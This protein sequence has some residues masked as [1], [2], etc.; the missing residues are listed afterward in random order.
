[1]N[2]NVNENNQSAGK[3]QP[4]QLTQEVVGANYSPVAHLQRAVFRDPGKVALI[5]DDG[6]LTAAQSLDV[7]SRLA[8]YLQDR[9]VGAGD[10]VL[11]IAKNHPLHLLTH[12]ACA[13]LGAV[14]C[15]LNVRLATAEVAAICAR[16]RPQH[17]LTDR[18]DALRWQGDASVEVIADDWLAQILAEEPVELEPIVA[19]EDAVGALVF[20]SGT[21]GE[22]KGALLTH[23]NLW[24]GWRNFREGFGYDRRDTEAVAAPLSHIGG[25]NGLTLDLFVSG[26]TVV[27]IRN[28]VPAQVVETL[29]RHGVAVMFAVPTMYRALVAQVGFSA[30]NLPEFRLPLV[31]GAP[32]DAQL[33]R[34]MVAKGFVPL[35]VWGM[36]ETA[37]SGAC[38]PQRLAATNP[39]SCGRPFPYT[40]LRLR[41]ADGSLIDSAGQVGEIEV[42]GPCV[43]TRWWPDATSDAW[44]GTGDL[45]RFDGNGLLTIVGREKEI[46]ISGGENIHPAEVDRAL[47]GIGGL[48]DWC[49]CGVPDQKWGETVAVVAVAAKGKAAP[50][51]A[52]VRDFL[53]QRLARFKLPRH[54][55]LVPQIPV[56]A[57][58]KHDRDGCSELARGE[59]GL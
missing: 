4:E 11:V 5:W 56:G 32:I 53:T 35:H 59:L 26:G 8:A 18:T 9:G 19:D 1:M 27:V 10:V 15:P 48:A 25:F 2:K 28:F 14:F 41:A 30:E 33:V 6:E 22:P 57:T 45:A 52:Q 47:A 3:A 38:L 36:T 58:G 17:I 21:T 40:N 20:T 31:G 50:S 37:G 29:R 16:I 44:L 49:T 24:W 7:V 34:D 55:V 43:V 42:S 51:L 12:V 39:E 13:W 54:L 46:I 23:A